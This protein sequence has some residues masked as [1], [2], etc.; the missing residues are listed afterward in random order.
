MR[1]PG[2]VGG[3]LPFNIV[4]CKLDIDPIVFAV[5]STGGAPTVQVQ[6]VIHTVVAR[7]YPFSKT[8]K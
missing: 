3:S 7:N 8:K 5:G 4:R 1:P 6:V 2:I